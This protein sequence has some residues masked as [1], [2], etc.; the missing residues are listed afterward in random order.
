MSKQELKVQGM[1]CDHCVRAVT[2]EFSALPGVTD[3][4]VDLVPDGVSS[5][6][7]EAQ[8]RLTDEQIRT[9]FADAGDYQVV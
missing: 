3:V 1:T 8:T 7:I 5:V 2:E 6:V 4:T 9:A